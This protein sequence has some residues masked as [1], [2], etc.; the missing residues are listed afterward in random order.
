LRDGID[1]AKCLA[2]G[3]DLAGLAGPFLRAAAQSPQAVSDML[4]LTIDQLRIS[5]FACGCRNLAGLRRLELEVI[6]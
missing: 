1:I 5:M 4:A 6:P 2:L 3:A